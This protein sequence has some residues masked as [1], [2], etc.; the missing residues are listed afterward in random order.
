MGTSPTQGAAISQFR[1]TG[2]GR[3]VQF[4]IVP[5]QFREGLAPFLEIL[6]DQP[7]KYFCPES[8]AIDLLLPTGDVDWTGIVTSLAPDAASKRLNQRLPEGPVVVL[9]EEL[10]KAVKKMVDELILFFLVL[11]FWKGKGRNAV[12]GAFITLSLILREW[13][14]RRSGSQL[15]Q[16]AREGH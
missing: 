5:G 12:Q 15:I 16:W 7:P 8:R 10:P 2:D 9:R 14:Y 6:V 3:P 11:R 4:N 1:E 13:G